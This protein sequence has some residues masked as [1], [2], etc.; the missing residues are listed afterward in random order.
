MA[1]GKFFLLLGPS[2]TGKGTI[3]SAIK[4]NHPKF[5][6]PPSCTTRKPRTGEKDGD[7]YYYLTREEFQKR[8]QKGDFLEY[9]IVH[10]N[11]YYGTLKKPILEALA[12]GK[13]VVR[14]V[15]VQGLESIRRILPKEQVV[16][17]FI[18]TPSWDM[19]H[20]RILRRGPM[21][22]EELKRRRQSYEKEMKIAPTC[23]HIVQSLEGKIP[24]AIADT[25][26]IFTKELS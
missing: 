21:L 4:K 19:L 12:A 1:Y 23:T 16:S 2:G 22:E 14:E 3:I 17:I 8:I 26:A 9:A 25:E 5:V 10:H 20:A 6:F 18:T 24:E 11:D 7:V 15:D 13:T